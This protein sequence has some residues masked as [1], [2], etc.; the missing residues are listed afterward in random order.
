MKFS[1]DLFTVFNLKLPKPENISN[2]GRGCDGT[3]SDYNN[4]FTNYVSLPCIKR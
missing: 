3:P 4:A 2:T 1:C